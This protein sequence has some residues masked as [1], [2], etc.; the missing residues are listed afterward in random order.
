MVATDLSMT[1]GFFINGF[2]NYFFHQKM[3]FLLSQSYLKQILRMRLL[4]TMG[5]KTLGFYVH[6]MLCLTN[7]KNSQ[8]QLEKGDNTERMWG[9]EPV[10]LLVTSCH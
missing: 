4:G 6:K 9:L 1:Q 10:Y 5:H 2:D 8:E 7:G 3:P